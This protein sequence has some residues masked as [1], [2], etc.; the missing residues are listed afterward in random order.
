MKLHQPRIIE[1]HFLIN[2]KYKVP[3]TY[4]WKVSHGIVRHSQMQGLREV[5][6]LVGN[7]INS[8]DHKEE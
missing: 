2:I 1:Y 6:Y 8:N 3:H 4:W 7:M 5:K